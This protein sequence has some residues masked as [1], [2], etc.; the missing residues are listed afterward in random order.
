MVFV[1]SNTP[2]FDANTKKNNEYKVEY[3][4]PGNI[5]NDSNIDLVDV[6]VL[7]KILAGWNDLEF[8]PNALDVDGDGVENLYDLVRLAQYLAGWDVEVA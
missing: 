6:T 5:N 1:I 2:D 8:N 3:H 7:A 4:D